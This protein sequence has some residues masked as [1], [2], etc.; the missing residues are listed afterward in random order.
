MAQ[1]YACFHDGKG[2]VLVIRKKVKGYFFH[3]PKGPGGSI[4]RDGQPLNGGGDYCFPGGR[5]ESNNVMEAALKEFLEE[6]NVAVNPTIYRPIPE[7]YHYKGEGEYYGVYFC[8]PNGLD[9]I[10][11][12][13]YG[14]L[15]KGE[16]AAKAVREGYKGTY[17]QLR[18]A[19]K[20]CPQDD[21]LST[22]VHVVPLNK[23]GEFF[24]KDSKVT[25]WFYTIATNLLKSS[26]EST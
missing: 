6:T 9:E 16:E 17:D 10:A 4:I 23:I 13:V 7:A 18:D 12:A 21:E 11:K 20:Y 14:N 25:G 24:K 22:S 2:S 19:Y 1:V 15:V 3:N 26:V 8:A 5:L